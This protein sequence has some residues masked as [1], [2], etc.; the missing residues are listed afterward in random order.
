M[1]F[2]TE[3]PIRFAHVDAAGIVFYPRYFEML[4]QVVEEWFEAE[5]GTSFRTL[6]DDDDSGVP[7]VHVETDFLRP[8]RLGDRVRFALSVERLG[9]SRIELRVVAR[10]GGEERLTARLVLAYVGRA[11]FRSQPIPDALR[12]RMQRF[13]AEA[14]SVVEPT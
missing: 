1:I 8:S 13:V 6:H 9:R 4:N 11:P 5:L 2:E 14:E 7:M 10:C 3:I 12:A